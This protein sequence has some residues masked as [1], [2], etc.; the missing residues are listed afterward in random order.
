MEELDWATEELE[1]ATEELETATEELDTAT[2]ELDTAIEEPDT[3]TEELD[4]AIEELET[5]SEELEASASA[6]SAS[7]SAKRSRT[8]AGSRHARQRQTNESFRNMAANLQ[9]TFWRA[10]R[11]NKKPG[12]VPGRKFPETGAYLSATT[13]TFTAAVTSPKTLTFTE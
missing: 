9:K 1:A 5:A 6:A 10:A 11:A 8:W 12:R 13:Q 7:N 4:A 3:A 2:E